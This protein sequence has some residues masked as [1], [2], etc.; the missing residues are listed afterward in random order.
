[1]RLR[2]DGAAA[3]RH[4]FDARHP[5]PGAAPREGVYG[6]VLDSLQGVSGTVVYGTYAHPVVREQRML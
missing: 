1:V 4:V 3:A 2:R 5:D 6:A